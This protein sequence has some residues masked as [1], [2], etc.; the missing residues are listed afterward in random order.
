MDQYGG[1]M[2]NKYTGFD[3]CHLIQV[4]DIVRVQLC[5]LP[6]KT[7]KNQDSDIHKYI[8]EIH[9]MHTKQDCSMQDREQ[10]IL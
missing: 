10:P 5:G 8:H 4:T 1:I 6:T 7:E 3:R 9:S 2:Q